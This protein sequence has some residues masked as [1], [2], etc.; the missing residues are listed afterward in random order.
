MEF[1]AI[2]DG[3][4]FQFSFI[5]DHSVLVTG[6]HAAYI[7]YKKKQWQC[8]DEISNKLLKSLGNVLDERL[9]LK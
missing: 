6:T 7:L 2:V 4:R 3:E 5:T 1:Y 8:A 9:Q